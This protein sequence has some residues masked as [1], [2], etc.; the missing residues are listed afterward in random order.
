MHI[1]AGQGAAGCY[2]AEPAGRAAMAWRGFGL[3]ELAVAVRHP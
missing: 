2:W 3:T 1:L